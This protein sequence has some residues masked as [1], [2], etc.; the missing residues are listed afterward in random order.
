M[1]RRRQFARLRPP[2]Q[3]R[4]DTGFAFPDPT[5]APRS[6]TGEK[7]K[8]PAHKPRGRRSPPRA[9]ATRKV[10][11]P[12][13]ARLRAEA[14]EAP[15]S[16]PPATP[17]QTARMRKDERKKERESA[18]E[19]PRKRLCATAAAAGAPHAAPGSSPPRSPSRPAA[20]QSP[21]AAVAAVAPCGGPAV[22]VTTLREDV[23]LP[24]PLSQ[25][26]AAPPVLRPAFRAP[27]RAQ[28]RKTVSRVTKKHRKA[29]SMAQE[30]ASLPRN[31]AEPANARLL[32][33]LSAALRARGLSLA[34]LAATIGVSPELLTRCRATARAHHGARI[35]ELTLRCR[36]AGAYDSLSDAERVYVESALEQPWQLPERK[37][38]PKRKRARPLPHE[39]RRRSSTRTPSAPADISGD[40]NADAAVYERAIALIRD[41]ERRHADAAAWQQFIRR[42]QAT[43]PPWAPRAAADV[44]VRR[45]AAFVHMKRSPWHRVS[46]RPRWASAAVSGKTPS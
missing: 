44:C 43:P 10:T 13:D 34:D 35:N 3:R 31:R 40:A 8:A 19:S 23:E 37:G 1:A 6:G 16:A 2:G 27:P 38:G 12:A 7:T 45:A 33:Q 5:A 36:W 46:T 28:R 15:R 20:E 25:S 11:G 32:A 18:A 39:R 26:T 21:T 42:R 22:W 41:R 29:T 24:M 4:D 9:K 14:G 17:K 30:S